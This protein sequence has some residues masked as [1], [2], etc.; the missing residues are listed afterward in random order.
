MI[1]QNSGILFGIC[2]NKVDTNQVFILISF[3][4]T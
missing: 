2:L 1:E 3:K 4:L